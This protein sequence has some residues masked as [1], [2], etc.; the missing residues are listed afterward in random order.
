MYLYD[1]FWIYVYSILIVTI[2]SLQKFII[3]ALL[4]DPPLLQDDDVVSPG[5]VGQPVGHQDSCL[6][7]QKSPGPD[8]LLEDMFAD[9][10]I[11]SA[12]MKVRIFFDIIKLV[13]YFCL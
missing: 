5:Q 10:R 9:M 4:A 3:G 13:S 1:L 2:G 6:V 7:L 8:D 12:K 11:N